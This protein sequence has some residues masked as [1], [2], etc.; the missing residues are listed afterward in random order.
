MK[1]ILGSVIGLL[2]GSIIFL[3][4]YFDQLLLMQTSSGIQRLIIT[5]HL[6]ETINF[7][8]LGGLIIGALVGLSKQKELA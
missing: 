2:I 6:N 1:V 8:L 4:L 7:Y 5:M 3:V